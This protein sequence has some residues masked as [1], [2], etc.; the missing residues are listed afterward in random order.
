MKGVGLGGGRVEV[1]KGVLF[2]Q[3]LYVLQLQSYNEM[4]KFL[5]DTVT[6]TRFMGWLSLYMSYHK[7]HKVREH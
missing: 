4:V 1:S 7:T 2:S 5:R 3:T 6:V